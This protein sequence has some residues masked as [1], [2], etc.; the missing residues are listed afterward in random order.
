MLEESDHRSLAQRLDLF[1]LQDDAPGMV[2]WHPRGF[3]IYQ[4]LEQAVREQL[5]AHGYREVRTPQILRRAVWEASGHWEHFY[6]GMFRVQDQSCDAAVK[7]VS[8]PGHIRIVQRSVPSYRELPIRL[9]EFGLVHRDEPSGTLHGLLR[10]RQFTQDDGHVFCSADQA[11]AEIMR[12]CEAV[13]PFYAHFG[14][15]RVSVALST[16]PASRAG[17]EAQWDHAESVLRAVM[18]R[19]KLPQVEQPG[20]GAF[21]GPKLEFVLRDRLDREWQC[22]TIQYDLVMPRSFDARYVDSSG[23]RQHLTMLHR[24]L[25]GSLERF[26]GMV[27]EHHAASLPCWLAPCQVAVLPVS[28][29][30][31]PWAE[32]VACRLRRA[33][34]RVEVDSRDESLA[35]RVADAHAQAA[36]WVVVVGAREQAAGT[37]TLRARRGDERESL[38]VDS[39]VA[40]LSERCSRPNFGG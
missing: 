4:L 33:G 29:A 6:D 34:L 11:E 24:A 21:Y 14:F 38:S 23:Q 31:G 5:Q 25:Y 12:F 2:F 32:E 37:V 10:L 22:G 39:A 8:C 27:L 17:D 40:A 16:R 7:P 13:S 35:R 19:L 20:A 30:Q 18:H 15:D 9:A 36:P 26:L 3:V 28:S 1:H